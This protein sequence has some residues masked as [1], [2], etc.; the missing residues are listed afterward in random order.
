MSVGFKGVA[1]PEPSTAALVALGL[2]A[3]GRR[4]KA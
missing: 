4:R 2:V 3:V 1:V